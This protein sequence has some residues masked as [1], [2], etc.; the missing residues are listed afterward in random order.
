MDIQTLKSF[1]AHPLVAIF[2][3]L[4]A[5]I[6]FYHWTQTAQSEQGSAVGARRGGTA[7]SPAAASASVD[8]ADEDKIV[9]VPG[10]RPASYRSAAEAGLRDTEPVIGVI[11]NGKA[12]AYQINSMCSLQTCLVNDTVAGRAISVLYAAEVGS[13]RVLTDEQDL[14]GEALPLGI[15]GIVQGSLYVSYQ[16]RNRFF[17]GTLRGLADH[18]FAHCSWKTWRAAYPD[19]DVYRA[20]APPVGSPPDA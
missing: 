5:P 16:G 17:D 20:E 2:A 10:V 3:L 7:D 19:T 9:G 11:V 1:V 14:P 4:V 8:A 15:H 6:G 13:P 18:P 12:R